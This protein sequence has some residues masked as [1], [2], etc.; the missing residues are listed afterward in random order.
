MQILDNIKAITK[1]DSKAMRLS[2]EQLGLQVGEMVDAGKKFKLP[3][4]YRKID[5]VVLFGM[6]GSSLGGHLVRSIVVGSIKVPFNIVNNYDAPAFVNNRT[7]AIC[8]SYSG[9]TEEVVAAY[10]SAKKRGA[11]L[12]VISTGGKL[13]TMAK[14]D[15]IP[16][17]IF[18]TQNNPCGSPRMGLGYSV[19]GMALILKTAG[20]IKFGQNEI[21][22][23]TRSIVEA[24]KKYGLKRSSAANLAKKIA[25]KTSGRSVWFIGSQHLSGSA[26]VAANQMNENGKRFGGYFLIPEL[27]HH[28]LEGMLYPKSNKANLLVILFESDNYSPRIAKRFRITEKILKD[29]GIRFETVKFS[30]RGN[31]AMEALVFSSYLSFYSAIKDFIDPTAIPFVDYFKKSLKK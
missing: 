10:S 18:S 5:R 2:I 19:I 15:K 11:K 27:N 21:S 17:F 29:N 25:L 26:H 1:I 23:I 22:N 31:Q 13:A 30:G 8:S 4:G 6:G 28:L 9:N 16:V 12:V 24:Q 20:V 14:K 7:L 3:A